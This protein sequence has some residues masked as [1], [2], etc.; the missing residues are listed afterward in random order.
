M[1]VRITVLSRPQARSVTAFVMIGRCLTALVG[2]YAA[3]AGVASLTAR[4]LPIARAEA[5]GWGMI[6]SFLIFAI[7]GLWAF[8]QPRLTRVATVI[9]GLAALSIGACYLLG[10]RA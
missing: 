2:G 7:L 1:D 10:V 8:H 9:W 5:T 3:A 6:I 4:L